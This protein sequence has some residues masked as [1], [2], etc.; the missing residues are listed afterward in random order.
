MKISA[1]GEPIR[2]RDAGSPAAVERPLAGRFGGRDRVHRERL[3]LWGR[4]AMVPRSAVDLTPGVRF[5]PPPPSRFVAKS[6]TTS[7]CKTHNE[8]ICPY[9]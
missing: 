1:A 5:P 8:T 6:G 3:P 4:W 9:P 7:L 2:T